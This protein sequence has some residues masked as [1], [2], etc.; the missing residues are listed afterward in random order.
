MS[1]FSFEYKKVLEAVG[2]YQNFLIVSSPPDG[3]SIGSTLAFS[4]YLTSLKKSHKIFCRLSVPAS[5]VFMPGSE[6]IET[7]LK[8]LSPE[9]FDCVIVFD[10]GDL[11]YAGIIKYLESAEPR[12]YVINI[13]HHTYNEMFGDLNVINAA[14]SSTTQVLYD[15]FQT[16][17]I[18]VTKDMATC[19]LVGILTDTGGFSNPATTLES[20]DISAE[21]V[22]RGVRFNKIA[23]QTLK[24]KSIKSL[25][26]WGEALMRLRLNKELGIATTV[27]LQDDLKNFDT[28]EDSVEGIA[29]F[30]NNLNGVK[31]VIVLKELE[32]GKIKGSL[33]TS[34]ADTDVSRLAVA[35]GGGG[36]QKAAG[37]KVD[38]KL[39]KDGNTWRVE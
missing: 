3:D 36:H 38:L 18:Q 26:L 32:G 37:F 21:L 29:N 4:A 39:L 24:N 33:R 13:D 14:A 7:D 25:R 20:L 19:L 27:I 35:M 23:A 30:L 9:K 1:L 34:R 6:K 15:Y 17:R 11:K 2:Q 12:P 28:D 16:N 5:L 10:A 22:K 8:S 31:A